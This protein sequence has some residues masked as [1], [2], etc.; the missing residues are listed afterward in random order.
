M[1]I[2]RRIFLSNILMI[3]LTLVI[4]AI[5]FFGVR[6][7]I[8]DEYTL[9]RGGAGGR[10]SD[11]P[12]IP[13][14]G[15]SDTGIVFERGN[16]TYM[17]GA[18]LYHSDMGDYIILMS[19]DYAEAIENRPG[20]LNFVV[21]TIIIYLIIVVLLGNVLIAKYITR[22]IMTPINTLVEGVH[23][24]SSG[25]LA[26]RIKYN[27]RDEFDAICSDFN[28]MASRLSDMVAQKL[29]VLFKNVEVCS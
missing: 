3:A 19:D 15:I 24:I 10:F 21:P 22:R 29:T 11:F 28:E 6:L 5:V 18:Y 13:V 12:H 16:F 14:A 17:T 8:V 7:A 4:G 9:T 2:G 20:T 26:H 25:N 27:R 1:T 23:K